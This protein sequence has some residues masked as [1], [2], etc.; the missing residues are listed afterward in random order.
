MQFQDPD[1]TEV[2]ILGIVAITGLV[3]F[4]IQNFL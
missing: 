2:I 3:S 4:G 1:R